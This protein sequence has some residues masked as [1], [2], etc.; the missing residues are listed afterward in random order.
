MNTGE[1]NEVQHCCYFDSVQGESKKDVIC[2]VQ[3]ES[4]K[5]VICLVQGESKKDVICLVKGERQDQKDLRMWEM[6]LWNCLS[7]VLMKG[8]KKHKK[9]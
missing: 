7:F 9:K 1:S 4:K 2:L 6:N 3:G 5:D 8:E